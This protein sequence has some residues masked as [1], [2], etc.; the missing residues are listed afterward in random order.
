[1]GGWRMDRMGKAIEDTARDGCG[2]TLVVAEG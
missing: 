1:M 2:F